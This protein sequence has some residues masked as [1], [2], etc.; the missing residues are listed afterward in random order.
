MVVCHAARG[1]HL[2]T[3]TV[4]RAFGERSFLNHMIPESERGY[5]GSC[6]LHGTNNIFE[7]AY[8]FGHFDTN[9][10][11]ELDIRERSALCGHVTVFKTVDVACARNSPPRTFITTTIRTIHESSRSGEFCRSRSSMSAL[12]VSGDTY[13]TWQKN[14][15]SALMAAKRK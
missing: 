1:F 4:S 13:F 10:S 3:V 5:A 14:W 11:S 2:S 9:L 15:S 6:L 12:A 8:P 7:M